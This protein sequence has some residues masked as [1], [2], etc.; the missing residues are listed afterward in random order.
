PL[1]EGAVLP[2]DAAAVVPRVRA[3]LWLAPPDHRKSAVGPMRVAVV[4]LGKLGAPLAAVLASK[5]NDV[6]GVDVNEKAV[7]L[8]N[9]GRAPVEEPGLQE[10]ITASRD[11]L[12]A[13]TEISAAADADA[14]ILLVPTPSNERGAFSNDN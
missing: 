9:S 10:L 6:V 13:T 3:G 11:R 7:E 4:G 1:R 8:V 12:S 14:S 2:V 5:G